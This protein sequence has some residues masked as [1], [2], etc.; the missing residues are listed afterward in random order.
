VSRIRSQNLKKKK[1]FKTLTQLYLDTWLKEDRGFDVVKKP[2][3]G[4]VGGRV[5]ILINNKI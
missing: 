1:T 4:R 3:G 5:A 2:R